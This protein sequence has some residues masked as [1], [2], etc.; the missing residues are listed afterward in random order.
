MAD[1]R[2]P[3]QKLACVKKTGHP[4]IIKPFEEVMG[5]NDAGNQVTVFIKYVKLIERRCGFQ[6]AETGIRMISFTEQ[7]NK[8]WDK[9][10][11]TIPDDQPDY[12]F[13]RTYGQSVTPS[14]W[15]ARID[16][17]TLCHRPGTDRQPLDNETRTRENPEHSTHKMVYHWQRVRTV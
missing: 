12:D 2:T 14:V 9:N 1:S 4:F 3:Y 8:H 10:I 17:A 16:W 15:N 6:V 11:I 7:P 13:V 5:V